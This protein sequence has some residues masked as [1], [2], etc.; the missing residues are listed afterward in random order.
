MAKRE[1]S[2]GISPAKKQIRYRSGSNFNA[3]Y[4]RTF[5]WVM[6]SSRGKQQAYCKVCSKHFSVSHGGID[7]VRTEDIGKASKRIFKKNHGFS[8]HCRTFFSQK[9]NMSAFIKLPF[10]IKIILSPF[11]W[12]LK[13]GFT[14]QSNL[15]ACFEISQKFS[16][17]FSLSVCSF[18]FD[19][20]L[21][22]LVNNFSVMSGRVV[23]D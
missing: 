6:P 7:D 22:A 23:L 20:I 3:E 9:L 11:E 2:P 15:F 18:M 16:Q 12:L 13:T 19:L 5:D 4:T 8:A 21:Y 14:V 17:K 1:S 10:V